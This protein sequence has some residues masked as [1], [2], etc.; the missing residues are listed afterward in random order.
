MSNEQLKQ[1]EW[2]DVDKN[3]FLCLIAFPTP[4]GWTKKLA[5]AY[6]MNNWAELCRSKAQIMPQRIPDGIL[7]DKLIVI[8]VNSKPAPPMNGD[9]ETMLQS[10]IGYYNVMIDYPPPGLGLRVS[11][12][13]SDKKSHDDHK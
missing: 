13:A 11:S 10:T 6:L 3:A 2:G 4:L 12:A 7:H 8:T 1:A 5:K 9:D